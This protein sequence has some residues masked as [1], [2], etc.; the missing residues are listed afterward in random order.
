[1]RDVLKMSAVS[2]IYGWFVTITLSTLSAQVKIVRKLK[3]SSFFVF[4]HNL[5]SNISLY[6][7]GLG[8]LV[9]ATRTFAHGFDC[10]C[11]QLCR[12]RDSHAI[13]GLTSNNLRLGEC[14][15]RFR[16][17]WL[18]MVH[19]MDGHRTCRTQQRSTLFSR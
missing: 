7:C 8:T 10:V 18:P 14:L 5:G 3:I 9:A 16:Y 13:F 12:H 17:N 4:I 19:I 2:V 11:R 6:T 1:M 15:L